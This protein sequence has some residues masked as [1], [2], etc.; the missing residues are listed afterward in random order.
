[1]GG[2]QSLHWREA[3][4]GYEA[5]CCEQGSTAEEQGAATPLPATCIAVLAAPV[6]NSMSTSS[7]SVMM[8]MRR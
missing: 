2:F 1:M 6:P 8:G 3:A 5:W 7:P 4:G